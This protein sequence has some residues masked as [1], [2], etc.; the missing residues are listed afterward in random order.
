MAHAYAERFTTPEE[1]LIAIRR[2]RTLKLVG[3]ISTIVI[4]VALLLAFS[5]AMYND[6]PAAA[7][8]VLPK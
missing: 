3:A 1:A 5:V 7:Q 2:G 4:G 8:Q 6:E